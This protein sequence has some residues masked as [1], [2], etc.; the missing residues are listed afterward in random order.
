MRRRIGY[1]ITLSQVGPVL[2][3]AW[4]SA[5]PGVRAEVLRWVAVFGLKEKD[6]DLAAGL[7]AKGRPLRPV[8]EATRRNRRSAMGPADPDAPALM[9]AYAVSRTRLLLDAEVSVK[10]G[11]V[12]FFWTY[13]AF[14]DGSWGKILDHHR[15]GIGKRKVKRDVIGISPAALSRIRDQIASRW[16][17]WKLAGLRP[18]WQ[19]DRKPIA[20]PPPRLVVVGRTDYDQFTYGIGTSGA[21][22]PGW[23][24]TGFFQRRPGDRAPAI[25]APGGN[26]R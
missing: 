11:A 23:Q 7:D 22:R 17:A 4:S 9:P 14:T 24:A 10:A 1:R 8:S 25:L 15:K 2:D 19:P 18:G 21:P 16:A 13:D 5:G 3:P 20:S 6:A 12:E 26:R